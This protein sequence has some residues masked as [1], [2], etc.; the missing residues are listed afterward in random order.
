MGAAR[1]TA[2]HGGMAQLRASLAELGEGFDVL[3]QPLRGKADDAVA[4]AGE[5]GADLGQGAAVFALSW[6]S[7][8]QAYGQSCALLGAHVGAA[9]LEMQAIDRDGAAQLR[10][11]Q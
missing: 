10:G 8:L 9:S 1:I 6:T 11:P 2:D 5:F 7:A 4:S 3:P